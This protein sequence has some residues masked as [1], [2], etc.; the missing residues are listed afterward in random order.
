MR[1]AAEASVGELLHQPRIDVEFD[2][3]A[4]GV[5]L[6]A[7]MEH[8]VPAIAEPQDAQRALLLNLA[9]DLLRQP[10]AHMFDDLLRPPHMRRDLGD[11]LEDEAEIADRHALGEQQLEHRLHAGIGDLRRAQ[12]VDQPLVLRLQ[13]IEQ[14]AHVL[15]GQQLSEVVVDHLAQMGQQH[16]DGVDRLEALALDVLEIGL[17]DRHRLHAEGRLADFVARHVGTPAVADNDQE[18]VGLE[19][20]RGDDGAVNADLVGLGRRPDVVGELDFR[21]DEAVL[22]REFAPH[23]GDARG[24]LL[25]LPQQRRGQFLAQAQFDLGRLQLLL[26][27]SLLLGARLLLA[28]RVGRGGDGAILGLAV[29]NRHADEGHQPAENR[30]GEERQARE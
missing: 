30:E 9:A 24:D 5:A 18:F 16:R 23:L 13:P 25:V 2:H 21:H 8:H 28:R 29:G 11:R 22:A 19:L 10:H 20:L 6:Q 1:I 15:V 17:R 26:D 4:L 12:L 27:R 3:F 14:R 7:L